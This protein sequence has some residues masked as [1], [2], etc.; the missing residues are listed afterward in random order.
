MDRLLAFD[1]QMLT[2][3]LLQLTNT[4]ILAAILAYILYNPVKRFMKNRADR[5]ANQI[6]SAQENMKKSETLRAEYEEKLRNIDKQSAEILESSRKRALEKEQQII[7][8]AKQEALAIKERALKEVEQEEARVKDSM[9]LQM[10]EI[11]SL[12]ASKFIQATMDESTQNKLLDE[13]ISDL[14]E[15]KWLN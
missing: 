7:Q 9:K 6:L 10:V 15:A 2:N 8:E 5:I 4:L 14:G 11:S 12:M 1:A 13:V 3:L